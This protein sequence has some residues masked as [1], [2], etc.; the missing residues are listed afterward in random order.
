METDSLADWYSGP[1]VDSQVPS[2]KKTKL[3]KFAFLWFEPL[4]TSA[5]WV[6]PEMPLAERGDSR[7]FCKQG[8]VCCTAT[9][10]HLCLLYWE[11]VGWACSSV[12]LWRTLEWCPL[13]LSTYWG[14]EGLFHN[15][16]N[17]GSPP[18]GG[19]QFGV[20]ETFLSH[21]C[22]LTFTL[23]GLRVHICKSGEMLGGWWWS[24]C[25]P[26]NSCIREGL[27]FVMVGEGREDVEGPSGELL[28]PLLPEEL[29][30]N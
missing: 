27:G 13:D 6:V 21:I 5:F 12:C 24:Y 25:P 7:S 17:A 11:Y 20:L 2:P 16:P 28:I 15:G 14:K 3:A 18:P 9:F 30:F 1:F 23:S 19:P 26:L 29:L 4:D 22:Y 10:L 8:A